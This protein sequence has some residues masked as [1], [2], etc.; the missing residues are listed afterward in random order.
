MGEVDSAVLNTALN[1]PKMSLLP[2]CTVC[3]LNPFRGRT[4][5]PLAFF[6]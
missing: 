2:F 1:L 6:S 3:Q 5:C 4:Q